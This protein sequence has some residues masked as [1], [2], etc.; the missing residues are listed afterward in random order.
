[1]KKFRLLLFMVMALL[2]GAT[3]QTM[4]DGT[5]VGDRT[6]SAMRQSISR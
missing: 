1:M 5:F 3:Q 6:D 4:A 2:F